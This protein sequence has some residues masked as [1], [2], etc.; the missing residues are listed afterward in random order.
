[1]SY[2]ERKGKYGQPIQG[3]RRKP[4]CWIIYTKFKSAGMDMFKGLQETM[5]EELKEKMEQFVTK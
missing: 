2:P 4:G 1:M 5:S 3:E